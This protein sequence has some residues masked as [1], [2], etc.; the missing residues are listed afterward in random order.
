M[1][2]YIKQGVDFLK[3]TNTSLHIEFK[4]H[5]PYF[6]GDVDS[7]DIYNVTLANDKHSYTFTFGNSIADSCKG[8]TPPEKK[9]PSAY[10]IL[11]CLQKT[12]V[13][14]FEEFCAEFGYDTDSA[15]AEDTYINAGREYDNVCKLFSESE[16]D[17][18]IEI[19]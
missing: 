3:K 9:H 12:P 19:N 14:S 15:N 17:L 13:G 6:H 2:K 4:K 5:A 8:K 7:R 18:L 16:I 11:C 1:D 10:S